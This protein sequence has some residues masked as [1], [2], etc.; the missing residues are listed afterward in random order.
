MANGEKKVDGTIL[1]LGIAGKKK[2]VK[3]VNRKT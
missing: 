1:A 2:S 3:E